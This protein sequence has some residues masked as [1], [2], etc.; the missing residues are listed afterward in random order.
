MSQETITAIE[1]LK[2]VIIQGIQEKKGEKITVLDLRNI[3]NASTSFFIICEAGSNTQV[4]A[5]VGSIEKVA[6]EV[7]DEKPW[8]IEGERE[9]QWVLMDFVNLVVHV[10]QK[11]VREHY[12]LEELWGDAIFE[13]IEE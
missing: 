7:L 3:E 12:K 4:N 9:A 8:H 5:I 1:A 10:F 6:L 13:T 2:Q 11:E